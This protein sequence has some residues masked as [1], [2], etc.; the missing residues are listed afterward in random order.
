MENHPLPEYIRRNYPVTLNSD[1]PGFFNTSLNKE[2]ETM[3]RL[4][5]LPL[6][7]MADLSRNAVAGSFLTEERK[8]DVYG[9]IDRYCRRHGVEPKGPP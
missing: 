8:R 9:E 5:N 4:H 6:S 2:Y 7:Q 3:Q 1:D